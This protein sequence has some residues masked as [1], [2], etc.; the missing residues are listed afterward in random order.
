MTAVS[1]EG[2]TVWVLIRRRNSS[3]SLSI[4]LVVRALFHWMSGAEFVE[5][6]PPD[7]RVG[8]SPFVYFDKEAR[9]DSYFRL[10]GPDRAE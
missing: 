1:A 5:T 9:A 4:A 2:S 10:F 7:L 3:W 6:L 8:A